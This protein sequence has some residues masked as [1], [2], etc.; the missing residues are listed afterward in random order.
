VSQ[1]KT[2]SWQRLNKC[3]TIANAR[4][5]VLRSFADIPTEIRRRVAAGRS[6]RYLVPRAVEELIADRGLYRR[7]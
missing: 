2:H 7:P 6:I 4:P 3:V 5:D 1:N